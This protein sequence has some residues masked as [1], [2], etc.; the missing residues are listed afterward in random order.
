[1]DAL[2]ISRLI[3]S[4]IS[5]LRELVFL[6]VH[7]CWLHGVSRSSPLLL[8]V[9]GLRALLAIVHATYGLGEE[10]SAPQSAAFSL[11][12]SS[13]QPPA[14]GRQPPVE[15]GSTQSAAAAAIGVYLP[16]LRAALGSIMH[17]CH[18]MF[19]QSLLIAS[20]T[21]QGE[22]TLDRPPRQQRLQT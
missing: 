7:F 3:S 20:K 4:L 6:V 11:S 17:T 13:A 21:S 5:F 9:I 1:M 19:G 15:N 16:Q 2:A 18:L 10:A 14:D 12:L 22:Q 8:Q